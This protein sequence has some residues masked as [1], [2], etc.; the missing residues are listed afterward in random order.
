[1]DALE[2]GMLMSNAGVGLDDFVR[3]VDIREILCQSQVFLKLKRSRLEWLAHVER[4]G[5]EM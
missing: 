1:M 3:T 4:L 5:D 2:I